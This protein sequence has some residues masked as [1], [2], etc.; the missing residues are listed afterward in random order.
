M[1]RVEQVNGGSI[2]A[3]L[4]AVPVAM[5]DVDHFKRFN[6]TFGHEAGDSVLCTLANLL[7]TQ[8]RAEDIICRYGG[9]E[10]TVILPDAS[11]ESSRKR[12][13]Q[14]RESVRG[15]VTE[16]RGQTLERITLS[17]GVSSFPENGADG[18]ALLEA[19]DAALYRAKA[20]GR[21]GVIVAV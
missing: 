19:A 12:A 9:E 11:L 3:K 18:K 14:L 20:Q 21:D 4:S 8:L 1:Q 10:F 16:F 6:D 5:V 15:L 17:I 13:E 7:R 2:L